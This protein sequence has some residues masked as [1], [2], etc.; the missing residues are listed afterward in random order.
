M[1]ISVDGGTT[2]TSGESG[3]DVE[4]A[5]AM[6]PGATVDFYY[7]PYDPAS[8]GP[9]TQVLDALNLAGTDAN[10][11]REISNSWGYE[12]E[13]SGMDAFITQAENIF[14]SNSATGHDYLFATGDF[15]GVCT[16]TG[17]YTSSS[18][19]YPASSP[20]V[21]AVGGTEVMNPQSCC[22][23]TG[24]PGE[25]AWSKSGGGYSIV[26]ARPPGR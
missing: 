21:T 9:T 5:S 24:Y 17:S 6:A 10:K 16:I 14:E 15:G 4:A 19:V 2:F 3:L 26:F 25:T 20:W 11:N 23:G 22:A 18:V 1:P 12:C 13:P 8:G 7:S